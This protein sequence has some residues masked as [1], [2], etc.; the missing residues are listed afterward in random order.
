MLGPMSPA[1]RQKILSLFGRQKLSGILANINAADL[2]FV[3]DLVK[4]GKI[5]PVIDSRYPLTEIREAIS[6]IEEGHARG[7]V[8]ITFA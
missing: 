8:I 5:K 3:G 4:A 2:A 1:I 7:K 6:Y